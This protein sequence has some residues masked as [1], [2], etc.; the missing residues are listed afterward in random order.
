[1][2][3][4]KQFSIQLIKS[5]FYPRNLHGVKS[6][7][8]ADSGF[9]KPGP[10]SFE[11][12]VAENWRRF[13]QEYDIFIAA[14]RKNRYA[15]RTKKTKKQVLSAYMMH[16]IKTKKPYDASASAL[17]IQYKFNINTFI[18]KIVMSKYE[19]LRFSREKA[20]FL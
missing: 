5:L 9:Q 13:S 2:Y 7:G 20:M 4:Y 14:A 3:A 17:L 8:M 19:N 15:V 12:N 10:H 1:M 16:A 6:A 11:G 18:E